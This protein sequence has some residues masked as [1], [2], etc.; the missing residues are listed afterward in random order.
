MSA[1]ITY[2]VSQTFTIFGDPCEQ[3]FA[4][5]GEAEA[6]ADELAEEI[7]KSFF[8]RN[9]DNATCQR[10]E[11]WGGTTGSSNEVDWTN[12]LD[13]TATDED[14]ESEYAEMTILW[15]DLVAACFEAVEITRAVV[16]CDEEIEGEDNQNIAIALLDAI[17]LGNDRVR[18]NSVNNK[19]LICNTPAILEE[20]EAALSQFRCANLKYPCVAAREQGRARAI[21]AR[22]NELYADANSLTPSIN[23][24]EYELGKL[25][26]ALQL[27]ID[28]RAVVMTEYNRKLEF[29]DYPHMFGE[30]LS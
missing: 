22:K 20:G 5:E 14:D 24:I 3:T 2:T 26:R 28:E 25:Q 19:L 7:P 15:A 12:S 21:Q 27:L 11:C 30:K 4:T 1:K 23:D 29:T 17:K 8:T 13:W 16:V 18:F 9:G 10:D 6:Y